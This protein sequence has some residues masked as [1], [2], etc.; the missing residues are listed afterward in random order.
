MNEAGGRWNARVGERG[1]GKR[2]KA[3]SSFINGTP[4][5]GMVGMNKC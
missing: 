4:G 2:Y 3:E 1:E 5:D